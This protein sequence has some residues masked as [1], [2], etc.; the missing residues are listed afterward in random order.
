MNFGHLP[1]TQGDLHVLRGNLFAHINVGMQSA[2]SPPMIIITIRRRFLPFK[3]FN[4]NFAMY[5]K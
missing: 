4:Y 3:H 1:L 5:G 2:S